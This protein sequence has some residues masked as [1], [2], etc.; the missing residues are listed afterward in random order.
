M[1]LTQ[2]GNNRPPSLDELN[3]VPWL[4]EDEARYSKLKSDLQADYQSQG[5]VNAQGRIVTKGGDVYFIGSTGQVGNRYAQQEFMI[6]T[7]HGKVLYT[8]EQARQ[9][10]GEYASQY[11]NIPIYDIKGFEHLAPA[12]AAIGQATYEKQVAAEAS[13][14][15]IE[16]LHQRREALRQGYSGTF[17]DYGAKMAASPIG[18][19]IPSRQEYLKT[20]YLS[21]PTAQWSSEADFRQ[22][23]A[24]YEKFA[25]FA[26]VRQF[27]GQIIKP[28]QLLPQSGYIFESPFGKGLLKPENFRG[29]LPER[30]KYPATPIDY[31]REQRYWQGL[32]PFQKGVGLTVGSLWDFGV[33]S[34]YIQSKAFKIKDDYYKT[35]LYEYAP[36]GSG[37]SLR[38][39]GEFALRGLTGE[40]TRTAVMGYGIGMGLSALKLSPTALKVLGGVSIG[41]QAASA[42]TKIK[43]KQFGHAIT[44]TAAFVL[45]A[46]FVSAGFATRIRPSQIYN[47]VFGAP[48]YQAKAISEYNLKV[49][50]PQPEV[51]VIGEQFHN[52]DV[53][54]RV[55][56]T[57]KIQSPSIINKMFGTSKA[58]RLPQIRVLGEQFHNLEVMER[59]PYTPKKP[60]INKMFGSPKSLKQ[61][62]IRTLNREAHNIAV[63]ERG[64][65]N[66]LDILLVRPQAVTRFKP[67]I[68][69]RPIKTGFTFSPRIRANIR[70]LKFRTGILSSSATGQGLS[71]TLAQRHITK[72]KTDLSTRNLLG[73]SSSYAVAQAPRTAQITGLSVS[74]A[75]KTMQRQAQKLISRQVTRPRGLFDMGR[76]F[77]KPPVRQIKIK[78]PS[79]PSQIRGKRGRGKASFG[80]FGELSG[81]ASVRQFLGIGRNRKGKLF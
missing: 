48:K 27:Q 79:K 30:D 5:S 53:M 59:V 25:P 16:Q 20:Q 35:K 74:Q 13:R 49:R 64:K 56:Y 8:E 58:S 45:S 11:L 47:K 19:P 63:S 75:Y 12:G 50:Q 9:K 73:L 28:M 71:D 21:S 55:P 29:A 67:Q 41:V 2:G 26:G 81:V 54:E 46:P 37:K 7:H 52:L 33:A 6:K 36:R 51:R 72:T 70:G 68:T 4:T 42:G 1:V 62:E 32:S 15:N 10:F 23:A 38:G 77:P 24:Q 60:L 65:L 78:L 43:E 61:P 3:P 17:T 44:E 40:A 31:G 76:P 39:A 80:K 69:G 66:V 22:K 34:S 18:T 57:P 14:A